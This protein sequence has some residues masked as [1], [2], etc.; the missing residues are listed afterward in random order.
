M[1]GVRHLHA[2]RWL[3]CPIRR[4]RQAPETQRPVVLRLRPL[5]HLRA[6]RV[7]RLRF[8]YESRAPTPHRRHEIRNSTPAG[9]E[10]CRRGA[11]HPRR[12]RRSH[13]RGPAEIHPLPSGQMLPR[14]ELQRR[15]VPPRRRPRGSS[16]HRPQLRHR[17]FSRVSG[18]RD[19]RSPKDRCNSPR[20]SHHAPRRCHQTVWGR[21]PRSLKRL[22]RRGLCRVWSTPIPPRPA[23]SRQ[24]E[25]RFRQQ[26][27]V[28][29]ELP[30]RL[31]PGPWMHLALR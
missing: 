28:G 20:R 9:S 26:P 25:G 6:C 14:R 18:L 2:R 17:D 19:S 22:C 3:L 27:A 30:S 23:V 24:C 11:L 1:A 21:H 15:P 7:L 13:L 29:V 31:P 16:R 4:N 8:R 5:G 10:P 12:L